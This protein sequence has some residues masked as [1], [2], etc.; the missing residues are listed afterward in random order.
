M[1]FSRYHALWLQSL[2]GLCLGQSLPTCQQVSGAS[3]KNGEE[4]VLH[5]LTNKF[6]LAFLPRK[7]RHMS[8]EEML[9]QNKISV[10]IFISF[11]SPVVFKKSFNELAF[12]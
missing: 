2:R 5:V 11:L 10:R 9:R 12:E 7:V 3:M 6:C 4:T 8:A 1:S